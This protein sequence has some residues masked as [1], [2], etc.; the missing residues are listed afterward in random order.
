MILAVDALSTTTP[1][2]DVFRGVSLRHDFPEIGLE[3]G[4]AEALVRT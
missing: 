2:S 4:C 1:G 3:C